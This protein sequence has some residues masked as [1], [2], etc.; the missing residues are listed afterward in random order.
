M[1]TMAM[2]ANLT[3]AGRGQPVSVELHRD[4]VSPVIAD[5]FGFT[6]AFGD[7][8]LCHILYSCAVVSQKSTDRLVTALLPVVYLSCVVPETL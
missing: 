4:G 2:F 6:A 5:D 7:R 1:V 8:A 3:A